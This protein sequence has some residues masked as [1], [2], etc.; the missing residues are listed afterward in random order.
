[1]MST[2]LV[3]GV[4]FLGFVQRADDK[5]RMHFCTASLAFVYLDGRMIPLQD[6]GDGGRDE[7]DHGTGPWVLGYDCAVRRADGSLKARYAPNRSDGTCGFS[8]LVPG[9]PLRRIR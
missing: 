6:Q 5:P 4:T 9:R 3:A 1:M 7:C 2:L 8:N